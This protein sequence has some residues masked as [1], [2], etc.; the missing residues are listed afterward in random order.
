MLED[1]LV[2]F[3]V[4]VLLSQVLDDLLAVGGALYAVVM[5]Q[6]APS[7]IQQVPAKIRK[8]CQGWGD[9]AL[10]SRSCDHQGTVQELVWQIVEGKI[11]V[12]GAPK[13]Q[14]KPVDS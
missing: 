4:L 6:H 7:F 10:K 14:K 9:G 11:G 5:V 1:H 12:G 2:H 3:A 8:A 13:H